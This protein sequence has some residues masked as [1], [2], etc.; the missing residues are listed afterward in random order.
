M[1]DWEWKR[2]HVKDG[3]DLFAEK[4]ELHTPEQAIEWEIKAEG[5]WQKVHQRK[6]LRVIHT[7]PNISK[8]S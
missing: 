2:D 7:P 6:W 8:G 3:R 5:W 4:D 1:T